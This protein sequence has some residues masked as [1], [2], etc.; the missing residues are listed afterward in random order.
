MTSAYIKSPL[1]YIGGKYKILN[2]II[3]CFPSNINTFIDLFGGGFNVGINVNSKRIIYNDHIVYLKDMFKFFRETDFEIIINDIKSIILEYDLNKENQEGYLRLRADYN[4]NPNALYLFVLTCFSFNHQ[5]RF[6]NS[7]EFNTP[8][9]KHRSAYNSF[10]ET[11]LINFIKNLKTKNID[12][13]ANDFSFISDY[14]FEE[15]DFVYCDPPYLISNAS[16]NDGKRG[17]KNWTKTED[18]ELMQLLDKLDSMGI[19]FLMSNVLVHKG[20]SNE[21]LIQ[22]S[23]KYNIRYIDKKYNNCNYHLKNKSDET[24]EVIIFNYDL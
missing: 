14:E 2:D 23:Q 8:F 19:K 6:N 10:I 21:E 15:N 9:G 13:F 11:N 20:C 17:F 4:R 1:N 7:R 16:Y 12:F 3:S 24:E 22:W 18:L 5:I